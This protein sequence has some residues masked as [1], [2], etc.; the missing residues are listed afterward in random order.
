M[1]A[2]R[3]NEDTPL[4]RYRVRRK[5]RPSEARENHIHHAVKIEVREIEG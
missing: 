2:N 4:A 1:T 5:N 3:P